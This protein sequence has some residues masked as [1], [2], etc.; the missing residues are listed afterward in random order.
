[1]VYYGNQN[2]G[3]YCL[4]ELL[5]HPEIEVVAVGVLDKYPDEQLSYGSVRELAESKAL[6]VFAPKRIND[7]SFVNMIASLG[8]D[9]GISVAWR[10]IFKKPLVEAHRKGIINFHGAYLPAFRGANPANWAIIEGAKETG[11]TVHFVDEGIDTGPI[12]LQEKLSIGE[13]ETAWELRKRQDEL[14]V[15]LMRKLARM[16]VEHDNLPRVEQDPRK[17]PTYHVR[18]PE[19]GLI[20]FEKPAEVVYNLIRALTKPYPGAFTYVQGRK[21]IIWEAEKVSSRGGPGVYLKCGDGN[22]IRVID[23]ET[24]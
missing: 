14:S 16:L 2:V 11:V 21:M 19:D 9:Y 20:N 6:R 18:K 24:V 13:R 8:V 22:Y 5:R 7:E 12:I 17:G 23:A 3:V 10:K 15:R 4:E 1:V